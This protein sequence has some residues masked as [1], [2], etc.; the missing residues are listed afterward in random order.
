MDKGLHTGM[1]LIDL[2]KAF[3]T[4]HHD[5]LLEKMKCI[6]FKKSVIKWSKSYL[7]NR[8]FFVLLE[9]VFL[10]EGLITCGVP[11]DSILG[12]LLFLIYI[13]ELLQALSETASNLY[14]YDRCIYY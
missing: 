12:S 1:I 8:K 2:Q 7:S 3:G 10:E 9:G 4:L 14:A 6:G 11:L 5:V 13:N